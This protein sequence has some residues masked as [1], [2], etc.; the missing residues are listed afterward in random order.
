M[1]AKWQKIGAIFT[2][3]SAKCSKIDNCG[4]KTQLIDIKIVKNKVATHP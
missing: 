1:T 2:L 4:V 3:I